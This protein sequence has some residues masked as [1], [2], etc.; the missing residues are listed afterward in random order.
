VSQKIV[1]ISKNREYNTVPD[2]TKIYKREKE[3]RSVIQMMHPIKKRIVISSL[4]LMKSNLFL[5]PKDKL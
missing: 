1:S 3:S 4:Y 5:M 2:E